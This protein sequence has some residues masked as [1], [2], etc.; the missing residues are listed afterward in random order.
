MP[1]LKTNLPLG[2]LKVGA[3][4]LRANLLFWGFSPVNEVLV[5]GFDS[6]SLGLSILFWAFDGLELLS[7]KILNKKINYVFWFTISINH[8]RFP[9]NFHFTDAVKHPIVIERFT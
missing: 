4:F 1:V 3:L 6:D 2:C 8:I 7:A 5:L 9:I